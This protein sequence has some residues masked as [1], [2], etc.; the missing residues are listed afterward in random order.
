M[1]F[2]AGQGNELLLSIFFSGSEDVNVY[3]C[4]CERVTAV[5]KEQEPQIGQGL[6]CFPGNSFIKDCI[7]VYVR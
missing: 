1:S 5:S 6:V 7:C 3:E 4:E 2:F